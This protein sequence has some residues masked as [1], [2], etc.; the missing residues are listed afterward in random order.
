MSTEAGHVRR[1]PAGK[2]AAWVE[3]VDEHEPP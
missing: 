2:K 3:N 1:G